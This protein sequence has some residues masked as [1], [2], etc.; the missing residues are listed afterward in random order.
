LALL[1]GRDPGVACLAYLAW[2]LWLL[3]YS[4]EA[5]QRN[6]EAL[7]LASELKHPF[8]LSVALISAALLYE[9]RRE[10]EITQTLQKPLSHSQPKKGD[11]R[12]SQQWAGFRSVGLGRSKVVHW[13]QLRSCA[14]D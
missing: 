2:S 9:F 6:K 10:P 3:G 11:S 13:K 12:K 8:S 4:K 7:A 14:K 1:Y 5:E